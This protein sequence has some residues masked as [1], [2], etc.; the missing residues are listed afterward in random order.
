MPLPTCDD[1][2]LEEIRLTQPT[3]FRL[4]YTSAGG[5]TELGD[6]VFRK[7]TRVEVKRFKDS[8]R[9]G[10]DTNWIVEACLLWPERRVW[11]EITA[12][13]LSGLPEAAEDDLLKASG[14]LAEN[15]LGKAS[16]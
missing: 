6:V 1:E 14:V 9:R 7:P 12:Q 10:A 4:R 11:N 15:D 13:E 16:S 3:A 5:R 2:T 8:A